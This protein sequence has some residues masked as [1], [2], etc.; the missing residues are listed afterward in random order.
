M[1]KH[2]DYR[3]DTII[4][5]EILKNIDKNYII[6]CVFEDRTELKDMLEFNQIKCI[7]VNNSQ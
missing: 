7:L 4:K 3:K 6:E 5:E 2:N 1:R